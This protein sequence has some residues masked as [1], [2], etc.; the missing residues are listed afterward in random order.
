MFPVSFLKAWPALTSHFPLGETERLKMIEK[1]NLI[2]TG[3]RLWQI[4]SHGSQTFACYVEGSGHI[5]QRL[6]FLYPFQSHQDIF[7]G[8]SLWESGRFLDVKAKKVFGPPL[9]LWPP[10]VSPSQAGLHSASSNSSHFPFKCS[11]QFMALAASVPDKPVSA[12]PLWASL[13]PHILEWQFALQLQ[14]SDVSSKNHWFSF[15]PY[16]S[17]CNN[18][19]VDSQVLSM[20]KLKPV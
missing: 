7:L 9:R 12:V 4:Y 8:S 6:F 1:K 3:I 16:F 13:S 15:C 19:S 10:G 20:P 2:L 17:G 18:K 5:S 11:S 14:Y